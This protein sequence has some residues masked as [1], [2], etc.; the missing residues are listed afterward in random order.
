MTRRELVAVAVA[1]VLTLGV[2]ALLFVGAAVTDP[3]P[4]TAGA[5]ELRQA[6]RPRIFFDLRATPPPARD[7]ADAQFRAGPLAAIVPLQ[8][9][10]SDG[11]RDAAGFLLV[12]LVTATTLVLA[13]DRVLGTYRAS[14]GGWRQ[15]GR[16][17]LTGVATLGLAFSALALGL[18][19]YLGF[20]S[21]TARGLFGVPVALQLGLAAFGV[22]L[23][24]LLAILAV[25][26][27]ATAW[28][29]GDALL[30]PAPLARL[31]GQLP[32]PAVAL[33]G[34]TF[35]YLIWQI[36]AVGALA[37]VAVIAYALGAVVTARLIEGGTTA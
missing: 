7:L 26:F 10:L 9:G 2:S 34:A 6:P 33:I 3:A 27:S 13:R 18:I 30:R 37:L 32:A 25:G 35:L 23:V 21:S 16:V 14:L 12:I 22:I 11:A 5:T 36:P 15:Q 19:V 29:V 8:R 28:H 20:V 1:F 31:Q 4:V 24:V 17:L